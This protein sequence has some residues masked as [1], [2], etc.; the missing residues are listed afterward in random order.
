MFNKYLE[1][2]LELSDLWEKNNAKINL[3]YWNDF[4]KALEIADKFI[5]MN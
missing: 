3:N 5:R 1:V 4:I 2:Y